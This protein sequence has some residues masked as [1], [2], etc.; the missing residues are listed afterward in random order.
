MKMTFC[1]DKSSEFHSIEYHIGGAM[2]MTRDKRHDI[3][4]KLARA[5][6]DATGWR[7]VKCGYNQSTYV[8]FDSISEGIKDA[9]VSE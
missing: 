7:F 3:D 9:L 6:Q 2:Y 5:I 1:D 4:V 8:N